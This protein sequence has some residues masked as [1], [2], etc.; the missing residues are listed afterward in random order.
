MNLVNSAVLSKVSLPPSSA[1]IFSQITKP[2][3]LFPL[4]SFFEEKPPLK[5]LRVK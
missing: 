5:I 1:A 3:P 2:Q 4:G